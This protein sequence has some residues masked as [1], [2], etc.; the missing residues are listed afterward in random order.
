[1]NLLGG[2]N[3]RRVHLEKYIRPKAGDKII[4]L[5]C[6]PCDI[7]TSLPQVDYTGVDFEQKYIDDATARFGN[8]GK[9]ICM[10]VSD[11][12]PGIFS[13][14]DIVLAT[15]VLH[16]LTDEECHTLF[17]LAKSFMTPKGRFITFDGCFL[18]DGQHPFDV[19]MLKNDRG[20]FVRRQRDYVAL[21]SRVFPVVKPNLHSDLLRI[22]YTLLIMECSMS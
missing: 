14:A 17:S 6:G 9:F 4:D 10:D 3:S 16:H 8:K 7:L 1:M 21:A 22:P 11:L 15:G 13:D 12:K 18:E 19:W 20:K 2:T 5:G